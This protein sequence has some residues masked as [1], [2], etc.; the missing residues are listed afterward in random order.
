VKLLI[1]K[2]FAAMHYKLIVN[3]IS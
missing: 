3:L 1:K 2:S